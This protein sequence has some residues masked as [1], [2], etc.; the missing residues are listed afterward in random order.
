M[1]SPFFLCVSCFFGEDEDFA[2]VG[3]GSGEEVEGAALAD[4]GAGA[5]F[6]DGEG[7][8]ADGE[9]GLGRRAASCLRSLPEKSRVSMTRK[10]RPGK[11]AMRVSEV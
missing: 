3:E 5:E 7:E 8:V 2:F 10:R 1:P 6:G 4:A 9:V 11:P